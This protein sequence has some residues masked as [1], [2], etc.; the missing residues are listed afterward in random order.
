MWPPALDAEITQQIQAYKKDIGMKNR[1]GVM[2]QKEGKSPFNLTG[3][4]ALCSY[5]NAWRPPSGSQAAAKTGWKKFSVNCFL[6]YR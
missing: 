4:I 3:Y 1:K 2:K 6:N 5:F